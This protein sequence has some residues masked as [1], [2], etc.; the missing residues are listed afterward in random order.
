MGNKEDH[1]KSAKENREIA[2][3]WAQEGNYEKSAEAYQRAYEDEK[4]RDSWLY[5]T[6][7]W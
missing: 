3:R 4:A 6:F 7:G 2:R 5:R 1:D